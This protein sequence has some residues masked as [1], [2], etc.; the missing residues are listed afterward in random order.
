[1][2]SRPRHPN[3]PGSTP[4]IVYPAPRYNLTTPGFFVATCRYMCSL[5]MSLANVSAARSIARPS[6]SPVGVE[7]KGVRS[8]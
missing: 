7:L 5:F 2:R 3:N 8:G 1:M 4:R 6:P